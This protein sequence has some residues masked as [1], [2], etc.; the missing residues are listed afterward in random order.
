MS[1]LVVSNSNLP[2]RRIEEAGSQDV[3]E[4]VA[5]VNKAFS[6][7]FSQ[8]FDNWPDRTT[9]EKLLAE[10]KNSHFFVMKE[11][12]E[13][14]GVVRCSSHGETRAELGML[15]VKPNQQKNGVGRSLAEHVERFARSQG[16]TV[17]ELRFFCLAA[18]LEKLYSSLGY[19]KVKEIPRKNIAHE[20]LKPHV[21][22]R[23]DQLTMTIM[24]KSLLPSKL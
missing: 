15:A 6:Q 13:I 10:M 21:Q 19:R 12:E 22:I 17:I 23:H 7:Y 8:W 5:L 14:V 4:I 24:E 20:T 18:S 9:T 1:Y 11:G 3:L 16:K 2:I